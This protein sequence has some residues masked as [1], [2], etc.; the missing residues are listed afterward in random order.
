MIIYDSALKIF[1]S[2]LINDK[3]FFSGFGTSYLGDGRRIENI[4]RFLKETNLLYKK[5]VVPKQIHSINIEIIHSLTKDNFEKID[6]IDGLI[7]K[8]KGIIL[9][10]FT[11]DCCPIIFTDKNQGIIGISHQGW[12][13]SVKRM[14]QKM[15]DKIIELGGKKDEI[16][17]AI[18]PSI[19]QCCYNIEDDRYYQFLEEFDGYSE[20]IF[21][22]QGGYWHLNIS[23][24]NYL[25]LLE[26]GIKKE[27]IDYFPFCTKC[28]KKRF[29]SFRREKR[30]LRGEMFN[31]ILK[32]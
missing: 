14:V 8:E 17:V 5:I 26:K 18:G 16:K 31:F 22:R 25:L 15:I 23:L 11:A 30:D 4:F 13:G 10:V 27:N 7:T 1:Y 21:Y 29:F 19:G 3:N 2:S 9:T 32:T 24:L 6:D 12:R 20:K 28:D